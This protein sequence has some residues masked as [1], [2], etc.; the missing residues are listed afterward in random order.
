MFGIKVCAGK[1]CYNKF[2]AL[3]SD[4]QTR[5]PKCHRAYKARKDGTWSPRDLRKRK[6]KKDRR[7]GATEDEKILKG[8]KFMQ[9]CVFCGTEEN[10]TIDHIVPIS[11][12]GSR[13]IENLQILCGPCNFKKA[14]KIILLTGVTNF[15][16][17]E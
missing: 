10:L 2:M 15:R 1:G 12:G 4:K 5:C 6:Q 13:R 16:E 14:D 9:K 8:T 17:Q 3:Y 7:K 11:K